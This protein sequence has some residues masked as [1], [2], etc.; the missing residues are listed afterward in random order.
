M[1]VE[2]LEADAAETNTDLIAAMVP[3]VTALFGPENEND[4]M[5]KLGFS[6]V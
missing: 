1:E 2:I 3:S 4:E 6:T 5:K